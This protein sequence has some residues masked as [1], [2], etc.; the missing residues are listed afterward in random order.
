[1]AIS[2]AT[3]AY[4]QVGA[5]RFSR[6]RVPAYERPKT[7]PYLNLLNRNSGNSFAFDYL[8][9]TKPEVELRKAAST[10]SQNLNR[11][12]GQVNKQFRELKQSGSSG[13]EGTGHTTGFMNH[14]RYFGVGRR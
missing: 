12:Q 4:S 3:P 8:Q 11:L 6:P 1:M 2:L 9:R 10:S 13:L 14:G 5:D 7:S